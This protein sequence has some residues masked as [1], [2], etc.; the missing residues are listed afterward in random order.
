MLDYHNDLR[1]QL[2]LERAELL[3]AEMRRSR[4]LTPDEAGLPSRPNLGE[5]MRRAMRLGGA[6]APKRHVPAYDA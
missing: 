1:R 3:A 4:R 2:A 5:L 6:T